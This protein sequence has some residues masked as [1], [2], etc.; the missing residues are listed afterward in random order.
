M[1]QEVCLERKDEL[2]YEPVKRAPSKKL[3]EDACRSIRC[4]VNEIQG[5]SCAA[6]NAAIPEI[7]WI[8]ATKGRLKSPCFLGLYNEEISR[9]FEGQICELAPPHGGRLTSDP[10]LQRTGVFT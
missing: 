10:H 9:L 4:Y 8:G 5:R 2:M 1:Q 6:A 3:S 7:V